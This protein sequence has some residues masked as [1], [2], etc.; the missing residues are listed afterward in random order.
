M[1]RQQLAKA[2]LSGEPE[3]IAII[4]DLSASRS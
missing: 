1:H 2:Q 4:D 3:I